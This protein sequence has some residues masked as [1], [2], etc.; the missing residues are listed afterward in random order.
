MSTIN[1]I[2]ATLM[3]DENAAPTIAVDATKA[4]T[5]ALDNGA[6]VAPFTGVALADADANGGDVLTLTIKFATAE[7]ALEVPTTLPDGVTKADPVTDA[8]TKT[9]TYSFSGKAADLNTFIDS[10]KFNPA[11]NAAGAAGSKVTT[12]F[13]L[14]VTDE[15]HTTPATNDTVKVVSTVAN[16]APTD[17]ALSKLTVLENAAAGTE[18]GVLSAKDANAGETFTYTLSSDASGA[19]E[20]KNGKLVV[21]DGSKLDFEKAASHKVKIKVADKANAVYEKELTI[22][23]GDVV[24]AVAGATKGKN[25]LTGGIGADK[26]NGGLGNDVLTGGLGSDVFVFNSKLGTAKTDRKVNFDTIKDFNVKDDVIWLDNAIFKKLGKGSEAAPGKLN[27]KFFTIGDKA[28]DGNDYL[29]Y[30]KKTGVLSY[31]ADGNGAGEAIEFAQ[32]KKGL[33]LTEKNFFIV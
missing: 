4:S 8:T 15:A 9:I 18:V 21:K 23:V 5:D 14:G 32:L 24:E 25:V 29:I 10:L 11:D 7:G 6:S 12:T 26:L 17:V 3:A 16:R 19:F 30:N 31:D 22:T 2:A 33:A 28:K 1:P 20:I 27:K 13:T